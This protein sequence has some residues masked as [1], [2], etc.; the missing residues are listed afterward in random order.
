LEV[1]VFGTF[2][3]MPGY[4]Q[5]DQPNDVGVHLAASVSGGSVGAGSADVN[6]V[7]A[8]SWGII[9]VGLALLWAGARVFR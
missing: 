5:G 1:T 9:I 8:V 4:S 3:D 2:T 6:G 7:L